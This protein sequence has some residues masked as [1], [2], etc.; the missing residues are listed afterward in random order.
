MTAESPSET[1]TE[2]SS[3]DK[4]MNE[5]N[6]FPTKEKDSTPPENKE[7]PQEEN[8]AK[9]LESQQQHQNTSPRRSD[10]SSKLQQISSSSVRVPNSL[11]SS[12]VEAWG[13]DGPVTVLEGVSEPGGDKSSKG[14][15]AR[16]TNFDE[17]NI[18][19]NSNMMMLHN[20]NNGNDDDD[21]GTATQ[22]R[23]S[24]YSR[25]KSSMLA[26]SD[27]PFAFRDGK[28]LLW[29]NVNMTLKGNKKDDPDR[30]LLDSVWGE[31][32]VT[33]TT[34]IMGPSGAGKLLARVAFSFFRCLRQCIIC[35][36]AF[37]ALLL[38]LNKWRYGICAQIN[39]TMHGH[40][41]T[42]YPFVVFP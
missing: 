27:D 29:R 14:M 3:S 17:A 2:S 19:E 35:L 20:N 34:A 1:T 22:R 10:V 16:A 23:Q 37:L 38:L 24:Q 42:C 11:R 25:R 40:L 5:S 30:K 6:Q 4:V 13:E 41:K 9:G 32:P 8:N 39:I 12:I 15:M 33:E 7:L 31:V 18:K 36:P 28:T 26:V 21:D